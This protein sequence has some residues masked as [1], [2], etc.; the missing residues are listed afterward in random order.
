MASGILILTGIFI[1]AEAAEEKAP[2][3]LSLSAAVETALKKNPGIRFS[4][5]NSEI[6]TARVGEARAAA[7]PQLE[8]DFSYL[9][10]TANYAPQPGFS[11]GPGSTASESDSSFDNYNVTL[12]ASQLLYDFGKVSSQVQSARKLA[13]SSGQDILTT[14]KG[15]IFNVKLAYYSLVQSQKILE[16]NEETVRQMEKH[17]DQAEGFFKVGSKSRFDVTKARVDLTTARFNLIKAKNGVSLA[18]VNL[19]NA[20]G[21]S[22]DFL[23]EPEDPLTFQ[24]SEMTLEEAQNLALLSR[25]ELLSFRLKKESALRLLENARDHFYPTLMANASYIDRNQSFPLVYNWAVGATMS[26]PFFNG[27]Q[28]VRQVDEAQATMEAAQAQEEIQAQTV[29][30][31]VRQAYLNLTAAEEEIAASRTVVAQSEE[32]LE[33]AEGRYRTGVGT[34]I[35][36]TDAEIGVSNAKTSAIQALFD[37]NL[38]KI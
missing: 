23:V 18:R 20:M 30:Q 27:F 32:N 7:L 17:L 3:K 9:R 33:L 13:E 6:L 34:A 10:G 26:F 19:N 37:Y 4:V 11:L 25:P 14:S 5:K 15:I 22:V 29:F 1:Q 12:T 35:E 28:T 16:V 38:A 24:R 31:D 8:I 21:V 36:T 2:V